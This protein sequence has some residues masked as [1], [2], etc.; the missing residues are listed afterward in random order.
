[1]RWIRRLL[2]S[3]PL[4]DRDT[5]RMETPPARPFVCRVVSSSERGVTYTVEVD[6]TDKWTCTCPDYAHERAV[7]GRARY[8]CKHCIR[9]G[10]VTGLKQP[11]RWRRQRGDG[12]LI[13]EIV[14]LDNG[15]RM[16]V[17]GFVTSRELY[18]V[19]D[20]TTAQIQRF[21]PT[22]D[23]EASDGESGSGCA[24]YTENRVN[25]VLNSV[26]YHAEREKTERRREGAQ[27]G[28]VKRAATLARKRAPRS[29][30]TS[31]SRDACTPT[32]GRNTA[33][34]PRTPSTHN[35]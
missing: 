15:S 21:L 22:P 5:P 23:E 3:I 1:M 18:E 34:T 19:H 24:L 8:F 20:M 12:W 17:D 31:I 29:A 4:F 10:Y 2:G 7:P 16:K 14:A 35:S 32:A 33:C 13:G 11:K 26:E 27:K 6:E 30:V 25:A 9:V 28:S